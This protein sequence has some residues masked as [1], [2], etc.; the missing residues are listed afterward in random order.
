[1]VSSRPHI[2]FL[3]T[4]TGILFLIGCKPNF[5]PEDS[6]LGP[7]SVTSDFIGLFPFD[8]PSASYIPRVTLYCYGPDGELAG[9]STVYPS[10]PMEP[11]SVSVSRL[12]RNQIY[13]VFLMADFVKKI[14]EDYYKDCWYQVSPDRISTCFM[15]RN[16]PEP[17]EYDAVLL[18]DSMLYPEDEPYYVS[19]SN[20]GKS[21]RVR[22]VNYDSSVIWGYETVAR[23]APFNNGAS[24]S[25]AVSS[26]S[27]QEGYFY[28]IPGK[29]S[30][31]FFNLS[32][33]KC[34]TVSK[35]F[36]ISSYNSFTVT[37]DAATGEISLEKD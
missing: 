10:N 29:S 11:F 5:T 2:V 32:A 20:L 35:S 16:F 26:S 19:L 18:F 3:A 24:A 27:V 6:A 21:G 8:S 23:F 15:E 25:I 34:G 7:L 22:V 17:S 28:H 14:S 13:S 12:K 1:M 36:D 4:L 9:Q 30:Y 33:D 31:L 37:A